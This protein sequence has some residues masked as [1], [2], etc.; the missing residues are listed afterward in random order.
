A[1]AGAPPLQRWGRDSNPRAN[2]PTPPTHKPPHPP[3]QKTPV[4]APSP[5]PSTA[6]TSSRETPAARSANR[7][8]P[9]AVP[10][11]SPARSN[12]ARPADGSPDACCP[13]RSLYSNTKMARRSSPKNAPHREARSPSPSP[14]RSEEHTSELQSL[15]HLV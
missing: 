15:R 12:S 14:C 1:S 4:A 10:S 2:S 8:P 7:P 13:P 9:P 6:K 3:R 5:L 11:A